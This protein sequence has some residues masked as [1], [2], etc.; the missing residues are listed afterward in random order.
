MTLYRT[1]DVNELTG[2]IGRLNCLVNDTV[3]DGQSVE[4][5]SHSWNGA[6]ADLLIVLI[7]SVKESRAVVL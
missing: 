6:V 3:D 4:V 1:K 2:I 7:E 5:E